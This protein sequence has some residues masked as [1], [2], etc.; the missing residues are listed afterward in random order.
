MQIL[1]CPLAGCEFWVTGS[2]WKLHES[3]HLCHPKKFHNDLH[4]TH[5]HA[6]TMIFTLTVTQVFRNFVWVLI[7]PTNALK[8]VLKDEGID[9]T[10][11]YMNK[12]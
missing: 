11:T 6:K 2:K 4:V 3:L 5:V 8:T 7:N 10:H 1:K 12:H 9:F